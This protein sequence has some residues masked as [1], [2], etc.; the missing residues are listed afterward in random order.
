MSINIYLWYLSWKELKSNVEYEKQISR[1][2]HN[3]D[4]R[5]WVQTVTTFVLNAC[6]WNYEWSYVEAIIDLSHK[7]LCQKK[8]AL[9]EK[10]SLCSTTIKRLLWQVLLFWTLLS[11]IRCPKKS[12]M[13]MFVINLL[14][15][16]PLNMIHS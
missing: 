13:W 15:G 7:A 16:S 2:S 10:L 14:I 3:F 5:H 12:H 8:I 11:C 1:L 4:N 9:Q 6:L